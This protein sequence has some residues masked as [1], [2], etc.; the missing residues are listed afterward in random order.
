MTLKRKLQQMYAANWFL[1]LLLQL[2]CISRCTEI[3]LINR[4]LSSEDKSNSVLANCLSPSLL[5]ALMVTPASPTKG[6][7]EIRRWED[8]SEVNTIRTAKVPWENT[9][10]SHA[11]ATLSCGVNELE[12][13]LLMTLL[14]P[15]L[16]LYFARL[17]CQKVF[18]SAHRLSAQR[19]TAHA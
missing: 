11:R 13:S 6:S 10:W 15:K 7:E 8:G 14:M 3:N 2:I 5:P 17:H 16:I 18:P 12:G 1:V 19:L 4:D 9:A